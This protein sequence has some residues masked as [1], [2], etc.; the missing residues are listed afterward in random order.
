MDNP[1]Q[2][3]DEKEA[4]Q[5]INKQCYHNFGKMDVPMSNAHITVP[6][7]VQL[8]KKAYLS[9]LLTYYESSDSSC[10][11]FQRYCYMLNCS[12]MDNNNQIELIT[13][14]GCTDA[15]YD[16]DDFIHGTGRALA[17]AYIG[18]IPDNSLCVSAV[19]LQTNAKLVMKRWATKPQLANVLQTLI[20]AMQSNAMT[21]ISQ[22]N[23]SKSGAVLR[24][25]QMLPSFAWIKLLSLAS[26]MTSFCAS[27]I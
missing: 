2:F 10:S 15:N 6:I 7:P 19:A 22:T 24:A 20:Y 4:K 25:F 8:C 21:I 14:W 23:L 18:P 11:Q 1:E 13:E 26:D 5:I 16:T 3:V 27:V 9:K 12:T 17:Q